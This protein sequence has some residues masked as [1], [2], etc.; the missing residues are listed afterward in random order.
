MSRL[1]DKVALIIGAGSGMGRA[2]SLLFSQEGAK[3]VAVD[4]NEEAG[5]KVVDEVKNQ[6]GRAAFV[7]ADASKGADCKNAVDFAVETYGKIDVVF[8][9]AGVAQKA[10][11]TWELDDSEFDR[12]ININTK[13]A[14]LIA[15]YSAL[16]LKK[17]HGS[18]ILI[19]STGA[20]RPRATQGLYGASKAANNTLTIGFAAEL[21]P[22]ARCNCINPGPTK[23]PMLR[24][25]VQEYTE[26]VATGI[27]ESTLLKHLVD[28]MDIANAA[29]FLASDESRSITG[30]SILVDSGAD[31]ARGKN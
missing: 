28:P 8:C 2:A 27:A 18:L 17:N 1:E 26:E 21:A 9:C 19:G 5:K 25:F 12:V 31:K 30:V 20:L 3:I 4:F 29:L 14:W 23:T 24:T 10:A 6:G 16:E 13:P 15:K 11:M 7:Y 22:E